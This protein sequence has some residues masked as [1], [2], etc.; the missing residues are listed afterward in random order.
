M[1]KLVWLSQWM[2]TANFSVTELLV[3]LTPPNEALLQA[4]QTITNW[5]DELREAIKIHLVTPS[6]FTP[7]V[8]FPERLHLALGE[9]GVLDPYCKA[10]VTGV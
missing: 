5:L 8:P 9:L 3:V 4:T 6:V 2:K 1:D 7:Y 10:I